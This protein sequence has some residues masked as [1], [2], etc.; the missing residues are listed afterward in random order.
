MDDGWTTKYKVAIP[1]QER[2][3]VK[4]PTPPTAHAYSLYKCSTT[5]KL[6]HFYY[7]CLNYPVVSTLIKAI[8]VG[9][10]QRWPGL[11]TERVHSHIDI[12][13]ESEQG[14]MNQVRQG[15]RSTQPTS[16]TAPIVHPANRVGSNMDGAPQELAN[17]RTHRVIMMAHLVTGRIFSNYTRCFLVTSNQGNAYI[18]LFYI[19]NANSIWSVPIKNRSKDELLHAVTEVYARLTARGY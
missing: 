1:P 19:Y 11:T 8:K 12:S 5:H 17:I 13:M 3:T 16:A 6:T 15:Q 10:L 9:Y 7:A 4:L 14:C 2:P 18:A